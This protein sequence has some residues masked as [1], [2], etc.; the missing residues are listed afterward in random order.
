MAKEKAEILEE[1][2]GLDCGD[3]G[4]ESCEGM[5]QAIVEGKAKLKD[6]RVLSAGDV[7]VLKINEETVPLNRFVQQTMKEVVLGMLRPLKKSDL[8]EGDTVSLKI[9]FEKEDRC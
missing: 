5:A 4:F 3:C 2:P 7:A 1:L 9:K 6:C 8:K